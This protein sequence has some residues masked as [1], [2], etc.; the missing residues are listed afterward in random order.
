MSGLG[1]VVAPVQ[2]L[3]AQVRHLYGPN[4]EVV[5][6][7]TIP[8][9][10]A[11]QTLTNN[12][13]LSG[14]TVNPASGTVAGNWTVNGNVASQGNSLASALGVNVTTTAVTT[15][16][17]FTPAESGLYLVNGCIYLNNGTSGNLISFA[18][19]FTDAARGFGHTNYFYSQSAVAISGANVFDNAF[20]VVGP[21]V[22]YAKGGA[23]IS[24]AY[25][26]PT[27]TPND[28]VSAAITRIA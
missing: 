11:G 5:L 12:G 16:L 22:I 24:V 6:D 17:S 27:N 13:T 4:G 14:G 3:G 21:L 15:I 8:G 23:A 1:G 7:L 26:D 28:F 10:P 19:R 25:Q 2:G 20:W 9:I 18:L